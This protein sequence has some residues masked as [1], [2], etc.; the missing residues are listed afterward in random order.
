MQNH[1]KSI[2]NKCSIIKIC[3]V[4]STVHKVGK[5]ISCLNSCV[6]KRFLHSVVDLS[7]FGIVVIANGAFNGEFFS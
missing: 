4:Q 7:F 2:T 1:H 6:T 3:L 5:N